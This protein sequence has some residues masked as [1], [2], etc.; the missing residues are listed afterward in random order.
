MRRWWWATSSAAHSTLPG[1][2]APAPRRYVEEEEPE[3]FFTDEAYEVVP[4][5]GPEP[6]EVAPLPE[7]IVPV[8]P[9]EPLEPAEPPLQPSALPSGFPAPSGDPLPAPAPDLP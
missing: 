2:R 3:E 1:W 8:E 6:M 7:Q 4:E 9:P 5:E